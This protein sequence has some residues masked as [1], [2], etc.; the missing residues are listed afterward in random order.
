MWQGVPRVR[1]GRPSRGFRLRPGVPVPGRLP[2][3][4]RFCRVCVSS[5]VLGATD[6]SSSRAGSWLSYL[7]A[8]P[9]ASPE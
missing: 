4:L 6:P 8:G 1:S 9:W 5:R 3:P 2:G 7:A